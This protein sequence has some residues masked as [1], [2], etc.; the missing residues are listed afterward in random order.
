MARCVLA[1]VPSALLPGAAAVTYGTLF[2][3]SVGACVAL[4]ASSERSAGSVVCGVVMLA[5]WVAYPAYCVR[6][7]LWR[8]R[9]DGAFA[10][11]GVAVQDATRR[12]RN[13]RT[14]D[15]GYTGSTMRLLENAWTYATQQRERWEVRPGG[16]VECVG[17]GGE[18]LEA[19]R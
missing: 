10:L 13:R 14:P 19:A 2:Q 4:V 3:P 15:I 7:V 17:G 9:V 16:V 12:R 5:A 11:S 18:R 8:G 6:E 1:V